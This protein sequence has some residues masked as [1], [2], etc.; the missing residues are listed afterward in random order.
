M[1]N[2][3]DSWQICRCR[4][5]VRTILLLYSGLPLFSASLLTRIAWQREIAGRGKVE[6]ERA[7]DKLTNNDLLILILNVIEVLELIP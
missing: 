6:E 2:E 3:T 7:R 4:L 5:D 1:L